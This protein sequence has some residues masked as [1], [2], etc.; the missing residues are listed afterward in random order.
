[1]AVAVDHDDLDAKTL[2]LIRQYEIFKEQRKILNEDL[3]SIR[4]ELAEVVQERGE[5]DEDGHKI[6]DFGRAIGKSKGLQWQRRVTRRLDEEK[7]REVLA[8]KV[9]YERCTKIEVLYDQDEIMACVAEG[10]L[11]DE[12]VEAMFPAEVTYALCSVKA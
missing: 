5:T 6:L 11:T 4:A 10:L 3:A 1:M 9:L 7:A 2:N 8:S 12:D